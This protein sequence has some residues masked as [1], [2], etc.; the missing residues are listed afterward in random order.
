MK[1]LFITLYFFLLVLGISAQEYTG[2]HNSPYLPFVGIVHQPAD[3]TRHPAKWNINLLSTNVGL[4]HNQN[5]ASQDIW[6]VLGKVGFG[7]LKFFLASEESLL[8]VKGHMMVPS[9]TYKLNDKHSFGVTVSVRADGIYNSSNDDFIN[10]FKGI[11]NPEGLKDIKDEYFRSLLNSW[12]EYGFAWSSTLVK[13]ENRWLS[14]G[15]VFKVLQ[16]SGA[17]YLE[18]DG[19]DVMFDKE[20]IAHFN[21]DMSYGFNESLSKTVDGGD[22]VEQSGDLGFGLDLGVSYSYLPDHL[23]GVKGVPYRYKLGFVVA[24]IG[25]IHHRDIKDQASYNVKME[26]VPYS[27]F[28]GITTIEALKDSIEKS[29]D[30]EERLGG[31]FR[32]NLPLT[33]RADADYCLA[34]NWFVSGSLVMKPNYYNSLVNIV[35]KTAWR[36]NITGRYES[37]KWGAYLPITYSNI[38]KWDIG[39]SARYR[40]F[41]IGSSTVIGNLLNIADKQT[42]IYLGVS[43]PIGSTVSN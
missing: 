9:I 41:F 1:Q 12:V 11:H 22:I 4:L 2:V 34:P 26:D 20:H 40:N 21:M 3:L 16:G 39:L 7:D 29:I 38:L 37:S 36:G 27:R 31:S 42:L 24:D 33:V 32:T 14:G 25:Q 35:S 28:T 6:D 19:I 10:I 13:D 5:F 43:I 30:F 17:G 18:M 8:Y 23:V 15:L